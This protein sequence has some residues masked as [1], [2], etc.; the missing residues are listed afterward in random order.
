MSEYCYTS[1][2][3]LSRILT[4]K[5]PPSLPTLLISYIFITIQSRRTRFIID[6]HNFGYTV[7]AT[8]LQSNTH[9][10]VRLSKWY[11]QRFGRLSFANFCVTKSMADVLIREFGLKYVLLLVDADMLY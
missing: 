4:D 1:A 9:P 2:K 10:F 5:N 11:E 8:K 6:W 3:N 7:L